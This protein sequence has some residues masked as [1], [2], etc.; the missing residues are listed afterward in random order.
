[1]KVLKAILR[2]IAAILT[3]AVLAAGISTLT[4]HGSGE[5]LFSFQFLRFTVAG[6]GGALSFLVI[7]LF[8]AIRLTGLRRRGGSTGM[9]G[10]RLNA[11]GFGM[12]PGAAVWKLFE[13]NTTLGR[14]KEVF[15]PLPE[16]PL[17]TA[18]GHFAPSWIELICCLICFTAILAW[19]AFR[20]HELPGNG[21]L[22]MT[23]VC[24]WG[25]FRSFTEHFRAEPFAYAGCINI[26]QI[27]LFVMTDICLAVWTVRKERMQ[28]STVFTVLQWIAVLSCQTAAVLT[29]GG[30]LS[31]G[32]QIGDLAVT[33][34]CTILCTLL[35]LL[36]GK[37]SREESVFISGSDNPVYG[38]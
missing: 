14:G 23:V 26:T 13:M 29:D 37:D 1:M 18:E 3:S 10:E 4:E 19:L 34:G 32:S 24:V 7:L 30:I 8:G 5:T 15:E 11:V 16:L 27:I 31:A 6:I 17:I 28:K 33:A 2:T 36:A 20:R 38:S 9:I 35:M 25:M 12:L 22:M 21:D